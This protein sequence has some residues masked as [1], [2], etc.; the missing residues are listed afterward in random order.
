LF[1]PFVTYFNAL[2]FIAIFPVDIINSLIETLKKKRGRM[3]FGTHN[4]TLSLVYHAM[5][6]LDAINDMI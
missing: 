4:K 5:H 6:R 2:L 1:A 3:E